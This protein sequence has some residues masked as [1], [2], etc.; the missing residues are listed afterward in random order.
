M[1]KAV[2]D[3]E[4]AR[5]VLELFEDHAPNTVANFVSLARKG[6]Y[7]GLTFH[8][9]VPGT[10]SQTGCP[11]GDGTGGPGY[12]I[13]CEVLA[14]PHRHEAGAVS[15]AHAGHD[16]GG[17]QFFIVHTDQPHLDGHHT[18]FGR[19]VEGMDAIRTSS[20]GQVIRRISITED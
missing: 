5:V 3:M 12:C 15:M 1:Y 8:R 18:V 10:L 2:I 20:Q 14:N 17:S 7:D 6:F 9:V 16:T 11:R 19:V 13:K 4:T